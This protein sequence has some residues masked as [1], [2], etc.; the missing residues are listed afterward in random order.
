MAPSSADRPDLHGLRVLVV[1]DE[2][3]ARDIVAA[4]LKHE[5]AE[6]QTAPSAHEGMD[7]V[8]RFLPHVLVSDVGMPEEDGYSFVARVRRLPP[9]TGGSTPSIALTAY[10]SAE[11]RRRALAAG[12]DVHLGKPI[13]LD[14]LVSVIVQL[15]QSS[16]RAAQP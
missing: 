11:D 5:G 6:V 9:Q 10:T 13:D 2:E 8:T 16:P 12:F 4:M 15:S 3:D 14:H 1:D 7:L